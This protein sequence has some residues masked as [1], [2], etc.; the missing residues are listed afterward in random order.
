MY[1]TL[2]V[3]GLQSYM[4]KGE[5]MECEEEFGLVTQYTR[6]PRFIILNNAA[7]R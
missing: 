5:G 3:E 6:V 2:S 1:R 4:K 7:C